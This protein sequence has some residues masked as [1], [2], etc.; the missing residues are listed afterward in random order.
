MPTFEMPPATR[1]ADGG[2]RRVGFELEFAG[3][4]LDGAAGAVRELFGGERVEEG[5]FRLRVEG[6]EL[7]DFAIEVDATL[8]QERK[9]MEPLEEIQASI[10]SIDLSELEEPIEKTLGWLAELVVPFEVTTPPIP[11]SELAEVDRLRHALA[12]RGA[13]GTGSRLRYAMG[14]HI[15]PEV[16]SVS[17]ASLC[18]HL[19]AFL[20]LYEQLLEAS[21]VDLTRSLTPFINPFPDAYLRLAL[22]PGYAPST[23]ELAAD[24]VAH[25]PTRNRPLDLLPLFVHLL[26]PEVLDGVADDEPLSARPTFH[27]R[28][29]NC[30]IDDPAWT[31]AEEW[32]RWV[33][34]ERLAAD[35]EELARRSAEVAAA[36]RSLWERLRE[37]ALRALGRAESAA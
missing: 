29:P 23:A 14:L 3:L 32:N 7:G 5:P 27:Y 24:Y 9:Y 4:D 25:N 26:G 33:E 8:L 11:L 13:L 18:D 17:A 21:D 12:G 15:N 16:P 35:P 1:N 31:V 20:V 36:R 37:R 19:R 34:V 10:E 6:S 30:R 2:E 22:A 28:L